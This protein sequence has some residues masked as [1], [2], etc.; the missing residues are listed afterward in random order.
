MPGNPSR[1]LD[2]RALL[3][4]PAPPIGR[5]SYTS[6]ATAAVLKPACVVQTMNVTGIYY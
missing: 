2:V 6:T 5:S 4:A 1:Q 3:V